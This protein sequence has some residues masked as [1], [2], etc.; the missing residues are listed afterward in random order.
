LGRS[1]A[2]SHVCVVAETVSEVLRISVPCDRG[3]PSI[4]RQALGRVPGIGMLDD[5]LLVLS[6]LV[7]NAVLYSGC[8]EFD[9]IE[10][11]VNKEGER[12]L[13][14]VRDPGASGQDAEVRLRPD[15]ASGGLG[16]RV[17]QQISHRWGA[18]RNEGYRVWAELPLPS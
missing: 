13:I 16:L 18:E 9:L 2:G 5:A 8:A 12:L 11:L 4:A 15:P 10:V 17:V 1:T 7:T 6:E 3:A 14:S